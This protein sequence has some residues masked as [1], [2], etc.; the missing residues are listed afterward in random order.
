MK[1]ADIPGNQQ[2]KSKLIRTVLDQRV[3]HAQLFH[4]AE[5]SDKLAL[6]IAYAQFINCTGRLAPREGTGLFGEEMP[7]SPPGLPADSCGVCSSCVKYQKLAHPDLHFIYPVSTTKKVT[8]KPQS[9]H[10]TDEWRSFLL[11]NRFS[12]SLQGWYE[13]IGIESKQGI[14]NAEDCNEIISTLSYKSYESDYK[15][16]IIWMVERLFHSAA[17][18]ILKILEEPPEKTLFLLISEEPGQIISTIL[19]RTLMVKIPSSLAGRN[20]R[21]DE[22]AQ[23]FNTFRQWMRD[24]YSA[25]VPPLISFASEISRAGREKHKSFLAYSLRTLGLCSTRNLTG[26]IPPGIDGEEL[27]FVNKFS[28]FTHAGNLVQL[29]ALLNDAYSHVERNAHAGILFLDL[30]LKISRL[31]KPGVLP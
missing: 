17:P 1:F 10:F 23:H 6:A 7:D 2:I 16:M 15:V 19:S 12:C 26:T 20:L 13:A 31:L 8:K 29:N 27:D 3:S 9:K 28:P 14:I 4:G 11:D 30:S 25:K 24:C 5:E 22:E 21:T 18:K